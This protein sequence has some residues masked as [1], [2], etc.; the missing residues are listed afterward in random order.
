MIEK[1]V[2]DMEML[3]NLQVNEELMKEKKIVSYNEYF[4]IQ[5]LYKKG[6]EVYLNELL[7]LSL[8][9]QIIKNSHLDFGVVKNK[10]LYHKNSY[11]G[12]DYMYIR[13]FLFIEKLSLENIEFLRQRVL[14]NNYNVDAELLQ[15]VKDT[16]IDVSKVDTDAEM[17]CYGVGSPIN[18]FAPD[19]IAIYINYGKNK[20]KLDKEEY[21]KNVEE[22]EIFLEALIDELK[23]NGKA[24]FVKIEVVYLKTL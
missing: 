19:A 23:E 21:I 16:Y 6:F 9:D 1:I 4:L 12:L 20:Q 17:V 15:L 5:S 3:D 22:K 2:Y 13:N 11:L 14:S 24:E 8:F 18:Q 7:G 10:D